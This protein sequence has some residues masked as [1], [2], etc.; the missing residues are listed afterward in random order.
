MKYIGLFIPLT[1]LGLIIL[2]GL[3]C[4]GG[5]NRPTITEPSET[6]PTFAA[7]T[8]KGVSIDWLSFDSKPVDV[9]QVEHI[10]ANP[11]PE[12]TA[13]V[14]GISIGDDNIVKVIATIDGEKP[15]LAVDPLS[16]TISFKP[17][18][19][20]K[21]GHHS[22]LV[23][24]V[25]PNSSERKGANLF[26]TVD[27]APPK[28]TIVLGDNPSNTLYV[29]FHERLN[30]G[31]ASNPLN[32]GFDPGPVDIVDSIGFINGNL[33]AVVKMKPGAPKIDELPGP[34]D[35]IYNSERGQS[36]YRIIPGREGDRAG[37]TNCSCEIEYEELALYTPFKE[38]EHNAV[39]YQYNFTSPLCPVKYY[40]SYTNRVQDVNDDPLN[41]HG[42][43]TEA[44]FDAE[45]DTQCVITLEDVSGGWLCT[46]LNNHP[47]T[48]EFNRNMV[49]T[50]H[51]ELRFDCDDDGIFETIRC[52]VTYTFGT[53]D[54]Q[55]PEVDILATG[56][57][58]TVA[59]E[60]LAAIQHEE[61]AGNRVVY[62]SFGDGTEQGF[63]DWLQDLSNENPCNRFALIK[64][65]DLH[66]L[67]PYQASYT[68]SYSNPMPIP[69]GLQGVN[70]LLDIMVDILPLADYTLDGQFHPGEEWVYWPDPAYPLHHYEIDNQTY[71]EL[72]YDVIKINDFI[73]SDFMRAR[74]VD[75][76]WNWRRT[77][78]LWDA[79]ATTV[80]E[81]AWNLPLSTFPIQRQYVNWEK[82]SAD[83]CGPANYGTRR[84]IDIQVTPPP[85]F[86]NYLY[87]HLYYEDPPLDPQ[88]RAFPWDPAHP[89]PGQDDNRGGNYGFAPGP[90]YQNSLTI[91]VPCTGIVTA[92]FYTSEFGGDN[93]KIYAEL[94]LGDP[95]QP[96]AILLVTL[97]SAKIE[98]WRFYSLVVDEM[99]PDYLPLFGSLP[100]TFNEAYVQFGSPQQV[101][102]SV[103]ADKLEEMYEAVMGWNIMDYADDVAPEGATNDLF[104]FG[105]LYH[106]PVCDYLSI[107]DTVHLQGIDN[108][109]YL[110]T[111]GCTTNYYPHAPLER[112]KQCF[113]AVGRIR[114]TLNN[115]DFWVRRTTSHEMGHC[116][117]GLTHTG[118]VME[119]TEGAYPNNTHLDFMP[120]DL[121]LVRQG[122]CLGDNY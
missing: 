60:L 9:S 100:V 81:M 80:Y 76:L 119:T 17:K 20:L 66:T 32:W 10:I 99:A 16:S 103:Y 62:E 13:V 53:P 36:R 47:Y 19:D 5:G 1:I 43:C 27:P 24:L 101:I 7:S 50:F 91:P 12:F 67:H 88:G 110:G 105:S 11:S 63:L 97:T 23:A 6:R 70:M 15:D 109:K 25:F 34:L 102:A 18:S 92:D 40:W 14:N 64:A 65:T 85:M 118:W 69:C 82:T 46:P 26:F 45:E 79:S 115:P 72:I 35:I 33:T 48:V 49:Q 31:Q 89:N 54:C 114:D 74:Y 86:L 38:C 84:C 55:N 107:K 111:L 56:T 57:G 61:E 68:D 78:R 71:R 51:S 96:G 37:Q 116:I 75:S 8:D 73:G 117:R 41:V 98:V 39:C 120:D 108:F 87:V 106:C 22:A 3:S 52:P 77:P 94:Y 112:H 83:G 113:I 42:E 2:F 58:A 104:K 21:P 29:F 44:S 30:P 28:I 4:R 59:Y 93:F 121:K 90:P 95:S 122:A